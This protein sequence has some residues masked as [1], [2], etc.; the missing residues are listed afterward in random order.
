M[1]ADDLI[2]YTHN[3]R[4]SSINISS[5]IQ[6]PEAGGINHIINISVPL[7]KVN[8]TTT[9]NHTQLVEIGKQIDHLKS[10]M[11]LS[12]RVSSHDVH[13]YTAIYVIIGLACVAC[14]ATALRRLRRSRVFAPSPA[15][16][17]AA[18]V[19]SGATEELPH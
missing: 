9:I 11:V 17:A 12:D 2:I 18:G 8:D 4:S 1:K 16:A 7:D 5:D 15:A 10:V 13:H 14:I 6:W 19:S 3:P